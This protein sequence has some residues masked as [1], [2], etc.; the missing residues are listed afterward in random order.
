M[1][2]NR[3]PDIIRALEEA[4][5]PLS[6]RQIAARAGVG[7]TCADLHLRRLRHAGDVTAERV[8]RDGGWRGG[9]KLLYTMIKKRPSVF[10]GDP[11]WSDV[12]AAISRAALEREKKHGKR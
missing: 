4:D 5:G 2:R 1:P 8:K 6:V 3:R 11:W 10:D 9:F 7:N 12:A